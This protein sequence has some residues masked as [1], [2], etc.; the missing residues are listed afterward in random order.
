MFLEA[1]SEDE[2]GREKELTDFPGFQNNDRIIPQYVVIFEAEDAYLKGR[3]K[4]IAATPTRQENHTEAQTDKRLKIY[5]ESNPS[6]TD[7][8]HL[9]FFFQSVIGEA[10]CMSKIC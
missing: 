5:R 9:L 6:A 7:P 1:I 8:K 4:E 2:A 10:A 3:A